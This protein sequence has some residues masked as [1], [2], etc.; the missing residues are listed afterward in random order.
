MIRGVPQ[1]RLGLAI[2]EL[3]EAE[4]GAG[5]TV[6]D[7]QQALEQK[8]DRRIRQTLRHF[9]IIKGTGTSPTNP[10]VYVLPMTE[11]IG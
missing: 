7:I 6:L 10:A 8:D 3:I 9:R 5:L 11:V 4:E 1:T 2:Q